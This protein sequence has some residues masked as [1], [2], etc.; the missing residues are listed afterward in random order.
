MGA[1]VTASAVSIKDKKLKF[2]EVSGGHAV[3]T[4]DYIPPYG[5]GSGFMPMQLY[6]VSLAASLGSTL[7]HLAGEHG[8]TIIDIGVDVRGTRRDHTPTGFGAIDFDIHVKS[9][10]I[11]EET[12]KTLGT[13]A[14]SKYCPLTTMLKDDVAVTMAYH[15]TQE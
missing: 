15:V 4:L 10:D 6:L 13:L 12:L 14:G 5:D 1:V 7:R 11:D 8:K 2:T 9:P 3:V